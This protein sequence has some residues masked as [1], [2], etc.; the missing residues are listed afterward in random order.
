MQPQ[1]EEEATHM[2][3]SNIR[4]LATADV[5]APKV[6]IPNMQPVEQSD[7]QAKR[8]SLPVMMYAPPVWTFWHAFCPLL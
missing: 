5:P 2:L 4:H 7:S 1:D 6:T 8:T 3:A